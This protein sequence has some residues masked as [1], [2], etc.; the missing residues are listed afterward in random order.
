MSWGQAMIRNWFSV[1]S[2]RLLAGTALTAGLMVVGPADAQTNPCPTGDCP[3]Q[4]IGKA[5]YGSGTGGLAIGENTEAESLADMGDI[6]FMISV[7]GE[8]V[9]ESET[10]RPVDAQ[11]PVHRQ[12]HQR[13]EIVDPRDRDGVAD[14]CADLFRQRRVGRDHPGRKMPA[15]GMAG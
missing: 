12:P 3:P 5:S 2:S 7:D 14:S 1:M 4:V 11:R 13:P 8:T 6:P 10:D 9:D 15:T